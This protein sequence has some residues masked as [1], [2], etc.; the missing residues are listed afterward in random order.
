MKFV[1]VA[2]NFTTFVGL[3][4]NFCKVLKT[5]KNFMKFVDWTVGFKCLEFFLYQSFTCLS[6]LIGEHKLLVNTVHDSWILYSNKLNSGCYIQVDKRFSI[7]KRWPL[8][9]LDRWSFYTV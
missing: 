9:A 8:V 7:V 6:I 4:N 1:E 2:N 3:N 5:R